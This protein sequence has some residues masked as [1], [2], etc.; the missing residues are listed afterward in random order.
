VN[1]KEWVYWWSVVDRHPDE[2][3]EGVSDIIADLAALE[4][5]CEGLKGVNDE[6]RERIAVLG[7]ETERSAEQVDLSDEQGMHWKRRAYDTLAL[8]G[9]PFERARSIANGIRVLAQR[10]EKQIAY[11]TRAVPAHDG[12]REAAVAYRE[13][14]TCY[15]IGKSPSEALFARLKKADAALAPRGNGGTK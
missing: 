4:I 9:V 12:L 3:K 2:I 10:Y 6:Q 14:A 13:L 8:Y 1:S 7:K 15:R 11:L 5:F